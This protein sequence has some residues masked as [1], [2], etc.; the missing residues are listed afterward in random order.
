M[1]ILVDYNSL[2]KKYNG[3]IFLRGKDGFCLVR[4]DLIY[5]VYFLPKYNT[6]FYDFSGYKSDLIAFPLHYLYNFRMFSNDIVVGEIMPYHAKKT[7]IN[8]IIGS[9]DVHNLI[10]NYS[11]MICELE[12]YPEIMMQDLVSS[13]ILYNENDGFSLIDTFDWLI[14]EKC[15]Y[16]LLNKRWFD[17]ELSSLLLG[18]LLELNFFSVDDYNFQNNL[19]KF[20]KSG[21]DLLRAIQLT[22]DDEYQ[23]FE[24]LNLYCWLFKKAGLKSIKTIDDMKEYTK[25]LKKTKF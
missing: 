15:N 22:L 21:V 18:N 6:C 8:S 9:T 17:F 7:I 19:M 12:K 25:R 2:L 23:I 11:L 10:K 24:I 20:G 13:N 3:D 14:N 1:K 16:F 4:D 5:K